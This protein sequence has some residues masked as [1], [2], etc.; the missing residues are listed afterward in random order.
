MFA[1]STRCDSISAFSSARCAVSRAILARSTESSSSAARSFSSISCSS[2]AIRARCSAITSS[3]STSSRNGLVLVRAAAMPSASRD[4]SSAISRSL[5][6][7]RLVG[8]ADRV[9]DR[10]PLFL[11]VLVDVVAFVFE[12]GEHLLLHRF[13]AAAA[14]RETGAPFAVRH[15]QLGF[16]L[17]VFL[18]EVADVFH[19]QLEPP[20]QIGLF[21]RRLAVV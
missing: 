15:R 2:W 8:D 6:G 14:R 10:G 21:L 20:L 7:Q 12:V 5:R 13:P 3:A 9:F 17:R 19:R 11:T 16:Q 18:L 1:A 4:L